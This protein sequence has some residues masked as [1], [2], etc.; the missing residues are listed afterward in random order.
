MTMELIITQNTIH[1]DGTADELLRRRREAKHNRRMREGSLISGRIL[2]GH[3]E[4]VISL[5]PEE[6]QMAQ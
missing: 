3:R 1:S 5:Y 2:G 6:L 4:N